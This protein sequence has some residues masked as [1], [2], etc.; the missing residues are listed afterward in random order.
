NMTVQDLISREVR[1][2]VIETPIGGNRV[3]GIPYLFASDIADTLGLGLSAK[4][5]LTGLYATILLDWEVTLTGGDPNY[6]LPNSILEDGN[7]P[8]VY[9]VIYSNLNITLLGD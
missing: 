4:S 7:F 3:D 6:E 1:R 9:D 5:N 8:Y 2:A